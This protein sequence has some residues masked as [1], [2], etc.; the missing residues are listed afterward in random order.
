MQPRSQWRLF[1]EQLIGWWSRADTSGGF[2]ADLVE[3]RRALEPM[4]AGMATP[5]AATARDLAVMEEALERM[6]AA[7]RLDGI[8]A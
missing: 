1:D 4:A 7:A 6:T 2:G 8:E 5:E 3:V